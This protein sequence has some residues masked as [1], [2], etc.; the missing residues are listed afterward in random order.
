MF[1]RWSLEGGRETEEAGHRQR[2]L[3][4]H[5]QTPAPQGGVKRQG[6]RDSG[7]AGLSAAR[8]QEATYAC[9]ARPA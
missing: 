9:Q 1:P 5:P 7:P 6:G 3:L 4:P 2:D 8:H